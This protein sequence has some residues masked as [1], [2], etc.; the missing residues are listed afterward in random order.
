M[1]LSMIFR[2]VASVAKQLRISFQ[3]RGRQ[4]C[5]PTPDKRRSKVTSRHQPCGLLVYL[6]VYSWQPKL[7]PA[8]D[9]TCFAIAREVSEAY[10]DVV[11]RPLKGSVLKPGNCGKIKLNRDVAPQAADCCALNPLLSPRI[12]VCRPWEIWQSSERA[13]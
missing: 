7:S 10:K 2:S 1:L 5:E 11:L 13:G 6:P 9:P 12:W 4:A 8:W 3:V